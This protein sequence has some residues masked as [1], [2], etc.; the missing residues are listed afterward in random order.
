MFEYD[1]RRTKNVQIC[2]N[3]IQVGQKPFVMFECAFGRND[4]CAV[5]FENKRQVMFEC[6]LGRTKTS[7]NV[8]I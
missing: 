7:S 6:A 3:I 4:K 8:Q 2:S 1:F 5:I